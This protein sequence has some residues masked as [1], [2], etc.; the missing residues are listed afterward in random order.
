MGKIIKDSLFISDDVLNL[1]SEKDNQKYL[2]ILSKEASYTS[3]YNIDSKNY[4]S[5]FDKIK[6]FPVYKIGETFIKSI[7]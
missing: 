3:Y 1:P 5:K 7:N 6:E 2:E 4:L